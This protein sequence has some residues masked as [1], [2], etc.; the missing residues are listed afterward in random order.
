LLIVEQNAVKLNAE[1][2]HFERRIARPVMPELNAARGIAILL[3]VVLHG[4]EF[5]T[6]SAAPA[7]ERLFLM[8][9]NQGW[10]G[11]NLFFVLSGF[12]ITGILLDS[13]KRSDY[14]S[15]FYVRRALR[16]LPAYYFVLL[17]LLLLSHISFFPRR[18]SL[19]FVSLSLIYLSNVS[20][21]VG[22]SMQYG[23]LWSLAVEE[24]FY[25]L[26]PLGVRK[27]TRRNLTI[28]AASIC[29]IEP[30]ARLYTVYR[31]GLWWGPYTWVS[32]DGLAL[33][34]LLAIFARSCYASRRI[35]F[36]VVFLTAIAA[37]G[38]M[39][40]SVV[41]PRFVAVAIR[42]TCVNYLAF[43]VVGG[44]LWVGTGSYFHV[45]RWLVLS[46]YG[47][48]SYGLYLIHMLCFDLYNGVVDAYIPRLSVG[49]NFARCWIRF[50]VVVA[51]STA[52]AYVSRVT[53]EEFFLRMKD[54][55]EHSQSRELLSAPASSN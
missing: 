34:A 42:G 6:P 31:G 54:K 18:T 22:I 33:G 12:L 39:A 46:F 43:A 2:A 45:V 38:A 53:F 7:W 17:L 13:V 26:W 36:I 9:V 11:V 23:P 14:Y 28:A 30:L 5:F 4:F 24:H 21:L 19:A 50:A 44:I 15:R 52:I 20:P 3:V 10:A 29:V 1:I 40:A 51:T 16:I 32:A 48:I 25:I 55:R 27:L 49:T 8:V 37:S 47:Y 41:T 35:L